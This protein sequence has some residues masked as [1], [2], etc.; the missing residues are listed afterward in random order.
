M[1]SKQEQQIIENI[2]QN[3]NLD[4]DEKNKYIKYINKIMNENDVNLKFKIILV[5]KV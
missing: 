5:Q 2:K 4:D 1:T 3:N